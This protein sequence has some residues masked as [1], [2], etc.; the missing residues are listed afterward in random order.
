M[1]Q[2][3]IQETHNPNPLK[4]IIMKLIYTRK[5]TFNIVGTMIHSTL[6]IP[7]NKNFNEFKASNDERCDILI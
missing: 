6:A 1:L 2:Y 5:T 4:P 7:I 3:Y